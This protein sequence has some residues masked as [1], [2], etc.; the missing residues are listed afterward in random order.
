[1]TAKVSRAR[2]RQI[3]DA[4]G[5]GTVPRNGL[6]LFAVGMER[7]EKALD[8]DL[9][10][11][12]AGSS[13]FKAVRGEYGSGKTFF[14]RWLAERAKRKKMATSEIQISDRT[15]P[16][17]RLETVYRSLIGGLSTASSPPSALQDIVDT[18]L[19][20]LEDDAGVAKDDRRAMS[21]AVEELIESRLAETAKNAPAFATALR[22]YR[23]ARLSGDHA[24]ADGLLAWVRGE[25]NVASSIRRYAGLKGDV[26]STSALYFL[27]GLLV[28][29]RDCGYPG[30]LVVL[31]EVETLQ[32]M[33]SD[34][35]ERSLNTLRQL[36]DEIDKGRFPGLYLVIT[37][38]PAFYDGQQGVQ[39]SPALAQRLHS[40]FKTDARFDSAR[41]VQ[42]RLTGFDRDK[43]VEL[44]C[45]VRDLYAQGDPAEQ[46]I[47]N[48]IDDAY[49]KDL[50]T[51]VAGHLGAGVAPRIFLRKLVADVLYR[52]SDHEDF[53]PR[54]DYR[55][56]TVTE[57]ELNDDELNAFR[58]GRPAVSA[59]DVELDLP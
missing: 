42:I 14:A 33:R 37:G 13:G 23:R 49:V 28:V 59:D 9:T 32:R 39:R 54:R 25:P 36:I 47:R 35:R 22:F 7:F 55:Q 16:L 1:M 29:L 21:T 26:D 30:L 40:D 20:A 56:V 5:R 6:D 43:L 53:D 52:V 10:A 31:D 11:V 58:R 48:L 12:T 19:L 44:G 57:G 2:R 46:R 45:A 34:N 51:A 4:L 38:T 41:S 8:D 50:A 15:T 27:Q 3:I 24:T 17:H 18:W